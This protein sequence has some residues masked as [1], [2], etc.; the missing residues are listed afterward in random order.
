[1]RNYEYIYEEKKVGRYTVKVLRDEDPMNP[2]V[3]CDNIGTMI[4]FHRKYNLGDKHNMDMDELEEFCKRKD[5]YSLPL[6]LYDHS[7]ITMSTGPFSCRWDSGQVG[8]IYV[9][10]EKYLKEFSK[11]RVD[12]KHLYEFLTAE[13]ETYDNYLTGDV[14]GYL[15]EDENGETIESCWGYNGDSKYVLEEG[16]HTAQSLIRYDI[17][18]HIKKVKDWIRNHVPL[19]NRKAL[20]V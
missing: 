4:C 8:R 13:V 9:E 11:K 2:R 6:Y 14:Y 10:R 19:E 7:G 5:V 12:K 17:K 16:I 15:V 1:M 20:S 3:E 18:Q